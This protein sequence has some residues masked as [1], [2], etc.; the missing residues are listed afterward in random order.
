MS[1]VLA[2]LEQ[3]GGA[4]HRV[5]LE[6]LAAAKQLGAAMGVPASAAVPGDSAEGPMKAL[7][8]AGCS[9]LERSISLLAW[10]GSNNF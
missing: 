10:S 2:I 9:P 1:G 7:P 4:W 5:S 6:T 8:P 3:Q